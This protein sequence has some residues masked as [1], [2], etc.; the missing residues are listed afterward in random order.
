MSIIQNNRDHRK[1]TVIDGKVA[2]T[3]GMNLAD[4]YINA[5]VRFGYWKD[6]A[7]RLTGECVWSFTS[8]FLELWDYIL[9]IESDYTFYRA[10]SMEKHRLQY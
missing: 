5:R 9:K 10:T 4:E 6:A 7:I 1:I 2:Y 8:M 3:G